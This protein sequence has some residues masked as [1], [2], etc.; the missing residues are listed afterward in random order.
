MAAPSLRDASSSSNVETPRFRLTMR[1]SPRTG[2]APPPR[3][4]LPSHALM[5]G[6][7]TQ[8]DHENVFGCHTVHRIPP[9]F[10]FH[11]D[12]LP[13][14]APLPAVSHTP[15]PSLSGGAPLSPP[16]LYC[17]GDGQVHFVDTENIPMKLMLPEF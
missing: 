17:H 14:N 6:R 3:L 16:P 4:S 13:T 10:D 7:A 11:E 5:E 9:D 15:G 2:E 8:Q 1:R 12:I